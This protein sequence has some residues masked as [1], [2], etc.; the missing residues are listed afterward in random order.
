MKSEFMNE[1][2]TLAREA[3]ANGEVPVGAVVVKNNKII[4]RGRNMREQNNDVF[5]HAECVAIKA[6]CEF[7]GDWRLD[8]CEI[9][10][11]LEPCPMC[12]GAILNSRIST[13]VFGAFDASFGAAANESR[14]NIFGAGYPNSPEVFG[15]ICEKSCK[16]LLVE[17]FNQKR[18]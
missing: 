14:V 11:T 2:I 13:V 18:G 10:V 3:A 17:F 9:Y 5:A 15:G 1:A 12:A 16:E 8:G 4:G 7:L 6:A